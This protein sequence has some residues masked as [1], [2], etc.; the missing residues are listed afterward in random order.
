MQRTIIFGSPVYTMDAEMSVKEALVVVNGKIDFT[1]DIDEAVK[2][3]PGADKIE[4]KGGCI[5][6][7]FVDANINLREFALS[8]RDIYLSGVR[9]VDTALNLITEAASAKSAGEWVVGGGLEKNILCCL[10]VEK[11]DPVSVENP[12]II[13]SEDMLCAACNTAALKSA[14]IDESRKDPMGGTIE[15]DERLKPSGILRER[16][17]DLVKNRISEVN[18]QEMEAVLSRAMEILLSRGITSFCDSGTEKRSVVNQVLGNLLLK[19]RLKSRIVIMYPEREAHTLGEMGIFSNFGGEYLKFGGACINIDGN[20]RT[21][22]AYMSR[23]YRGSSNE[24]ILMVDEEE[25]S[26]ILRGLYTNRIWAALTCSGDR[27]NKIAVRVLGKLIKES[28][29]HEL[30]RRVDKATAIQEEDIQ[31]FS[32]L[33]IRTVVNPAQ[34]PADRGNAIQY[35]GQDAELLYRLKSLLNAGVSLAFGSDAPFASINPMFIIYCAVERKGFFDGPELR[36]YPRER[37]TIE[38]AV[39]AHSMGGA[40]ACGME[41]EI[42]SLETAK[43]ADFVHLSKDILKEDPENL[44]DTEIL[45][46]VMGGNVVHKK[47]GNFL[48]NTKIDSSG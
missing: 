7:G 11:L 40:M 35:L 21:Q 1:G 13:Y 48:N 24:G 4:L 23:H 26:S 2:R 14:G 37:I 45:L 20:L 18:E 42:G 16:A 3:Y 9:D 47:A 10:T 46:T 39:Y 27:A 34:I 22:S 25:L 32:R 41:K 5:V 38:Q 33:E 19:E 31:M 30:I 36:F 15:R 17:V 6:P 8:I 29:G 12:V 28:G 44:K 43:F